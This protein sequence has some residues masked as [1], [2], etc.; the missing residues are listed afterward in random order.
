MKKFSLLA[1]AS[2]L[3][4]T[5]ITAKTPKYTFTG[6]YKQKN[7]T[8][9]LIHGKSTL[10]AKKYLTLTEAMAQKKVKVYETGNVSELAI[11]NFSGDAAIFIQSGD[12]VKGGKQDRV[13]AHDM[14]LKPRSGKVNIASFC[15]EKGRWNKRQS[16]ALGTFSQSNNQLASKELK[17]AAKYA[18]NQQKVWSEVEETQKKMSEK[19]KT[20]VK[21]ASSETSLQLTLENKK[22]KQETN[23]YMKSL[24]GI[25]NKQKNVLGFAFAING[26]LNS[27]DIYASDSLF[28]KLWPKLLKATVAEAI[29]KKSDKTYPAVEV[30]QVRKWFAK[31]ASGK[32]SKR[33]TNQ[34]TRVETIDSPKS[35][36][37]DTFDEESG[38]VIHQ[39]YL[40]K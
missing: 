11:E 13:F 5:A 38:A 39:N 7:L 34:R 33:K 20:Q 29:S 28:K 27:A 3:I 37:F 4:S 31:A 19:L 26:E 14:V 35:L 30:A 36:R 18:S 16:E 1:L 6:P 17:I 40:T 25:I 22:L 10:S 12:I 8:I 23:L 21:S 24:Q 15:V 9:F 32:K 2:A